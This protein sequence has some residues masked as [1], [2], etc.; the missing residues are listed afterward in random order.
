MNSKETCVA[1]GTCVWTTTKDKKDTIQKCL[2][3]ESFTLL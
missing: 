3:A 1:L 2:E